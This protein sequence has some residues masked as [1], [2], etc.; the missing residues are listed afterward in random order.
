[1]LPLKTE[2]VLDFNPLKCHSWAFDFFG[3][4]ICRVSRLRALKVYFKF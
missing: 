3:Q 4:D 1:M 2:N